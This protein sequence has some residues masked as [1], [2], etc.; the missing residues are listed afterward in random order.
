M[1]I[2]SLSRSSIGSRF[3]KESPTTRQNAR[4][5][6]LFGWKERENMT[7]KRFLYLTSLILSTAASAINESLSISVLRFVVVNVSYDSS[8]F[9]ES[10]VYDFM[11]DLASE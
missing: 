11:I 8:K 5:D 2:V 3:Q 4:G 7:E 10:W 9:G 1:P 6:W